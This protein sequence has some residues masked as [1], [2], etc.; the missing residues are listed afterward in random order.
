MHCQ[1][2]RL[3]SSLATILCFA[4]DALAQ[5]STMEKLPP[6][7]EH[8][9]YSVHLL[10]H[11]IGREEYTITD[12]GGQQK[13]QVITSTSDRIN[14]STI[15]TT[16]TMTHNQTPL[17]LEQGNSSADSGHLVTD[18]SE[19]KVSMRDGAESRALTKPVVAFPGSGNMPAALQMAMM[20]YWIAHHRPAQLPLLRV[21][22]QAPPIEIR[23]AGH[24]VFTVHGTVI[25]LARYTITNL[26]FGREV[27]WMNES[28]RV[29]AV[30]TFAGGLP[31]EE[32][33]DEYNSAFDQLMQSGI[34]E[35]MLELGDI[36]HATRPLA[37]G[38]Y[39][40]V[41]ARVVDTRFDVEP[42]KA[43]IENATVI[44]RN[45]LIAAVGS[46]ATT[47]AP[48]GFHV[49][50]ANGKTLLPGLWDMH[51]H[52]SGIA[53]GPALLSA[54]ITTVR[55]CGG[56]FPFLL[57]ARH[58]IAD[59]HALG[60][61]LLL[62]GL[63]DGANAETFGVFTADTPGQGMG[64]VD[65]YADAHFDQIKVYDQIKPDVLLGITEEAHR[66]GMTVTG[67]VP[68][69]VDAYQGVVDGMDQI[70]HLRFVVNAMLPEGIKS[71]EQTS[72]PYTIDLQSPRAK[73]LITLLLQKHVVIDPALAWT[74]MLRH[75]SSIPVRSFQPGVEHVPYSLSERF[76]AM[77]AATDKNAAAQAETAF[78]E[79]MKMNIGVIDAL[80]KAG[81]PIVAGSDT[82]VSGY[83]IDREL[84]L[85]V[86]AG[87][88]PLQAIQAATIVPARAM[89][90]DKDSGSIEPGKR[91]DMVL[92]D[93]NP[94]A[95]INDL[96][97]VSSVI[98]EGRLYDAKQLAH[99]V[100]FKR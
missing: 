35:Q 98:T 74:E 57:A 89:H 78:R 70:N 59:E 23:P 67:H 83:G 100:G 60:P 22:A 95:N 46:G 80:F 55:D 81:V 14:K 26:I 73:G 91:A 12:V 32:I 38:N 33:L 71:P 58:A 49:I 61:R 1:I 37:S 77:G 13:L 21:S 85:Y 16:L 36:S 27:L 6:L 48:A 18:M 8:G 5:H 34:R 28:N 43:V 19:Q 47:P 87:M 50:R 97:N 62:A 79:W 20:R 10:M 68:N 92:V 93:G 99:T 25:R 96:R 44:V 9:V 84:E 24:D 53:F 45:G 65:M 7:V 72:P 2:S 11:T 15:T 56:E 40:I 30:M 51:V 54:G 69:A 4:P 63:I 76:E 39:A 17:R 94:L 90:H 75:P 29:A 66:R 41:G 31:R 86:Q 82:N 52:Y 42:A 64:D 88:T 3:C